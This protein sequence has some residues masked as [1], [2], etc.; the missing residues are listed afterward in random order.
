MVGTVHASTAVS[1]LAGADSVCRPVPPEASQKP[2]I[3]PLRTVIV[4][5]D[6]QCLLRPTSTTSFL[7]DTAA[8][9]GQCSTPQRGTAKN[10]RQPTHPSPSSGTECGIAA[11][12]EEQGDDPLLTN[13]R[14]RTRDCGRC[15]VHSV[16]NRELEILR[17][18][19]SDGD[20]AWRRTGNLPKRADS[21]SDASCGC[22]RRLPRKT[23]H[24]RQ[25]PALSVLEVSHRCVAHLTLRAAGGGSRL[26]TNGNTG[27]IGVTGTATHEERCCHGNKERLLHKCLCEVR[28]EKCH[29]KGL[30]WGRTGY[31]VIPRLLFFANR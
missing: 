25:F 31:G 16:T 19:G 23:I 10:L 22:R 3:P 17:S 29:L 30:F 6:T 18:A 20:S 5:G 9:R 21:S 24:L 13:E 12:L 8:L 28:C 1:F 14:C 2:R 4:D 26:W 7:P 15:V 27:E 11:A